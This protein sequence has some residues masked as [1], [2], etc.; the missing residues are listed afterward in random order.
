MKQY[1]KVNLTILFNLLLI[2]APAVASRYDLYEDPAPRGNILEN[3][4]FFIGI[5]IIWAAIGTMIRKVFP[6][7]E[8]V[9]WTAFFLTIVMQWLIGAHLSLMIIKLVGTSVV[10][11]IVV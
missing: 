1:L 10:L 7:C 4:V 8:Y 3:I 6:S 11:H 9:G 2:Q 5:V